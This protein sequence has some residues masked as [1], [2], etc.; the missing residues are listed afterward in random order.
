M[1]EIEII[2]VEVTINDI[3]GKL[4]LANNTNI[5]TKK[6]LLHNLIANDFVK[7]RITNIVGK[8]FTDSEK[9]VDEANQILKGYEKNVATIKSKKM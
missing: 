2:Q 4:R 7:S 3:G 1:I 6:E 9:V 5:V 8:M